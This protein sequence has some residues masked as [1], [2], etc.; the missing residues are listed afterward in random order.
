M[1]KTEVTFF[2]ALLFC[3]FFTFSSCSEPSRLKAQGIIA[4]EI[5]TPVTSISETI[6]AIY[7]D[8]T[9]NYWLGSKE[10][11]VF[12]YNGKNLRQITTLDGLVSN[13]IRGFQED[14]SGNIYIETTRGISKFDG[15]SF[16]TLQMVHS[17]NTPNRWVLNPEDLWFRTGFTNNGIYRFDG[18]Y[19]HLLKLSD[20]PQEAEF[21]NQNQFA[22]YSPYGLYTLYKDRKGVVWF[23]TASLGVCRFD[24]NTFSWHY[25]P[26]LQ[27]TP[28]GG[29]FG[30]RAVFEDSEGKFWINNTRFRYNLGPNSSTEID[31][32]KEEGVGYLGEENEKEFPF[33]LSITEDD[34]GNLWMVTYDNGVWKYNGDELIHYPIRDDETEV[35]LFT[36]YKDQSGALWLGSHNAGAFKFNGKTFEKMFSH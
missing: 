28:S 13:E 8:K 26:Q 9:G 19:L 20:A 5:G 4:P 7:Q 2:S 34:E 27:T 35:L 29:D 16:S 18:D 17:K 31:F 32:E 24:G 15:L 12:L 11:G 21:R 36:I 3:I 23:G 30:T 25:E 6:W 1:N 22:S 33:F 14:A 10:N